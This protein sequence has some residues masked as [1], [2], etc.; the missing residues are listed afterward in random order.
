MSQNNRNGAR[1]GWAR[2]KAP[3]RRTLPASVVEL[4]GR[5]LSP[6]E[7]DDVLAQLKLESQP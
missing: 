6:A 1:S 4:H 7:V 5:P 2:R 3:S